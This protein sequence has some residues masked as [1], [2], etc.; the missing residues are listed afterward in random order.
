VTVVVATL[1]GIQL[2]SEAR[3]SEVAD[4]VWT[5]FGR[6]RT[7]APNMR[8]AYDALQRLA[9]TELAIVLIGETGAGKT[10]LAR[11]IHAASARANAPLVVL[12]FGS[13]SS[14]PDLPL[15][16]FEHSGPSVVADDLASAIEEAQG[17]TLLIEGASELPL[18]LQSRLLRVLE[19]KR[20]RRAGGTRDIAVD[21]RIVVTSN[22]D[23]DAEVAAN[24][25]RQ[26][27]YFRLAAA[28]VRIAPLRDRREDIPLLV[29][30]LLEDLGSSHLK[31]PPETLAFL[32]A[33]QW[34]GNVRELKN[35]LACALA[36]LD[37]DT[38]ELKQLQRVGLVTEASPLDQLSL[39][40]IS[41]EQ[42]E[43]AAIRQTLERVRGNKVRAAKSLG[44]AVSTLYEKLKRL[45]I[46]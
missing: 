42:I 20:L 28:V 24:R 6:M 19:S 9:R 27:L 46:D 41:L 13:V 37:G 44:I 31:L 45:A 3:L 12:D 8:E 22:R 35:A 5:E 21:L 33:R 4:S 10:K 18:E 17:G 39:A 38:L 11:A 14:R 43:R 1:T 7:R 16:G 30:E 26:D 40:G 32:S 29:T 23:L 36:L 2:A 15:T 34:F 25:F